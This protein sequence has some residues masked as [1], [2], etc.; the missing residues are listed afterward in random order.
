MQQLTGGPLGPG[1]PLSP[2]SPAAPYEKKKPLLEY[3][4]KAS[5]TGIQYVGAVYS[6]TT[7]QSLKC[8]NLLLGCSTGI[9]FL[10]ASLTS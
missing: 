6:E 8:S 5:V 1:G 7:E 9:T 10:Q 4:I 3:F 2:G